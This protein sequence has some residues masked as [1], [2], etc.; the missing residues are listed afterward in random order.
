MEEKV[1]RRD[2]RREVN[3]LNTIKIDMQLCDGCKDCYRSCFVDVYRWDGATKRPIVA[4]PE[5]CV[6]C[7]KCQLSCP[8]KA[9]R[10]IPDFEA[11][12]W[13]PAV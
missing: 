4:Y 3:H 9:I 8:E 11:V 5:D 13:P 12:Y 6:E 2:Y 1:G 7:N 10:V